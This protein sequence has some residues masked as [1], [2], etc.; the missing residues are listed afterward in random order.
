MTKERRI[1]I[2]LEGFEL[3][4]EAQNKL[5]KAQIDKLRPCNLV[6]GELHI[7][8]SVINATIIMGDEVMKQA[9]LLVSLLREQKG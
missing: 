7:S 8:Q 4:R 2:E 5:L 1:E 6:D 3:I 9:E